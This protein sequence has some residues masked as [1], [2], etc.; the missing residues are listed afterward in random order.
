M[1][2]KQAI[3]LLSNDWLREMNAANWADLGSGKG[4]FTLALADLSKP[5]SLIYAV[6]KDA[7]ALGQ[8]VPATNQVKI[9]KSERTL[10]DRICHSRNLMES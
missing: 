1:E 10:A 6:D 9:E 5:G 8:I 2:L 7:K 4:T 3:A